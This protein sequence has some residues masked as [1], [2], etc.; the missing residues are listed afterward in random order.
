VTRIATKQSVCKVTL[1]PGSTHGLYTSKSISRNYSPQYNF[2][3]VVYIDKKY[4]LL[5]IKDMII[6]G[7]LLCAPTCTHSGPAL[8]PAPL[9][10]ETTNPAGAHA[11]DGESD[12]DVRPGGRRWSL[13]PRRAPR[14]GSHGRRARTRQRGGGGEQELR[15]R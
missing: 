5:S 10:G 6:S 3:V 15:P 4:L 1:N 2:V 7:I 12:V 8:R 11:E 13:L 14:G 9:S